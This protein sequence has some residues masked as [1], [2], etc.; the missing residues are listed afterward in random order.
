M[1][2]KKLL[3]ISMMASLILLFVIGGFVRA[4][5]EEDEEDD[6]RYEDVRSSREA[7]TQ[8]SAPVVET[9]TTYK[10]VTVNEIKE[11]LLPDVDRDGIADEADPHPNI[12]EIYIVEDSNANGI[13]DALEAQ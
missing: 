3:L 7:E 6:D 12:A 5:D 4:D 9:I 8:R 11:V 10:T 1:K 2:N 13:V